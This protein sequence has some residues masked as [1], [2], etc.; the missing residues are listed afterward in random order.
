MRRS[1]A[2]FAVLALIGAA[3]AAADELAFQYTIERERGGSVTEDTFLRG[4]DV[5]DGLRL[6][7][8]L[9]Q[10]SYCYVMVSASAGEYRLVFPDPGT[11]RGGALP[12]NEWARIPKST[13]LRLGEDPAVTRIIIVVSTRHVPELDDA[14]AKGNLV[15]SEAKTFEV[16][17]RY[18]HAEAGYS[19]LPQGQT[20]SVTYR[21]KAG[22]PTSVVEEITPP[23]AAKRSDRGVW[24]Q[25][26]ATQ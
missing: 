15:L 20:V 22:E 19:R 24:P 5:T 6:K 4:F 10:T 8:K 18:R 25:R 16:R 11:L 3:A 17:D 12:L 7:V 13:F 26:P 1:L 21:T 23:A 9:N 2:L 14:A